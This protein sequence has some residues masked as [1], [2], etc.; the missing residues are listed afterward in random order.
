MK[1]LKN[2]QIN[3]RIVMTY[4]H[5]RYA[6]LSFWMMNVLL[7][8]WLVSDLD[9]SSLA[10]QVAR[11]LHCDDISSEQNEMSSYINLH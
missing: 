11:H 3:V 6:M 7:L 1:S 5:S 9:S 10:V 8:T 2:Y 4:D